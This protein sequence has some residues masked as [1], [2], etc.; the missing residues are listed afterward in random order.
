MHF[1]EYKSESALNLERDYRQQLKGDDGRPLCGIWWNRDNSSSA[2]LMEA[3][4]R[5]TLGGTWA[6]LRDLWQRYS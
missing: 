5:E 2:M 3:L 6:P 4:C 1:A